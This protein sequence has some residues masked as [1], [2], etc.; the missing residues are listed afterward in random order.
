MILYPAIDIK[1][2]RCVRLSQGSFDAVKVYE[3]NPARVAKAW[4]DAGASWIHTVDL[5]GA[6]AGCAVNLD[7]LAAIVRSVHIPVQT[8]GGIRSMEQI[9]E[10]LGVG[11]RRVIIGTA[12]VKNP[13]FLKEALSE[14]GA[15]RILVGIDARDG[16][17]A[18]E[19]WEEVSQMRA[20]ELGKRMYAMGLRYAVYTDIARDGMLCGPNVMA[21]RELAQET[22]LAVIASGGVSSMEDLAALSRAGIPGAILGK[23]LY[24]KRIDLAQAIETFERR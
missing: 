19:G 2:G 10:K 23:S 12:A 1:E 14:Y 22:G 18:T 6:L 8:G 24:E 3:E 13:D 20:V 16:F 5:D 15:E 4:E 21:T 7:A 9:E 11:I 17:V